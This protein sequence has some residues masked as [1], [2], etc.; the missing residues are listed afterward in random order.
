MIYKI[1]KKKIIKEKY[2]IRLMRVTLG[3]RAHKIILLFIYFFNI[4]NSSFNFYI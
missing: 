1:M 4:Y 2:N 3:K